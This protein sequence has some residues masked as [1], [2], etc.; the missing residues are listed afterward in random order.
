MQNVMPTINVLKAARDAIGTP[1][2]D[3]IVEIESLESYD[4]CEG[5]T[6]NLYSDDDTVEDIAED[7]NIGTAT[8]DRHGNWVA[9]ACCKA[10]CYKMSENLT[11]EIVSVFCEDAEHWEVI[12]RYRYWVLKKLNAIGL[13]YEGGTKTINRFADTENSY[14]VRVMNFNHTY[15]INL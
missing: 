15:E 3:P 4:D 6:I 11:V 13:R 9:D 14:A 1:P 5:D 10:S 8:K 2:G 12:E 7:N